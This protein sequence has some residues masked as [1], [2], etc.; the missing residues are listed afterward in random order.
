MDIWVV[1]IGR[2]LQIMLL[3]AFFYYLVFSAHACVFCSI[4]SGMEFL[5]RG[6][7]HAVLYMILSK[8]FTE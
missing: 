3:G 6:S 5:G 4:Y 8:H 2:L 1:V 7:A